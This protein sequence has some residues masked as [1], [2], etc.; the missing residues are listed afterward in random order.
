[1]SS[2]ENQ[3]NT[4]SGLPPFSTSAADHEMRDYYTDRDAPR[5]TPNQTPYLT[6]YL[7]LNARLSQVWINRWTI[8]LL[9]VLVRVLFAIQSTD[10]GLASARREAL[11]ACTS[12]EK[13]GSAMASMPHYMSQGVNKMTAS[14]ITKAVNGLESMV[15][16][17]VTGVEE[18]IV[19]Y[20]GMLTNTYLCLTTFA[21]T[22]STRAVIDVLDDAQKDINAALGTIGGDLNGAAGDLQ[23]A[24]NGI[25][26]GIN[27]FTGAKIP[28]ADFTKQIDA[29]KNVKI[30]AGL[31]DDLKKLNSSLP[32]FAEVKNVTETALRFPFEELKKT[33]AESMGR[34]EFNDSLFPV[35][36]KESLQFC[37]GNNG[38]NDF[39]DDLVHIEN[40][41]RKIFLGTLLTAAI[42]VC[43]PMAWWEIQRYR[44]LQERAKLIGTQ[45]IDPMDAVYMASRPY[46]SKTGQK[47]A[48]KFS[49]P[50]CKILARWGIAYA[51]SVPAL[52]V[53]SLGL[54]GLFSCL[55]QYSLLRTI[56][57]QVPALTDQVANFSG[58]V[59][60]KLNNA[61][62]Q[63]AD[64]TNK[65]LFAEQQKLNQDLLGWV[66]TSTEAVNNTLTTFVDETMKI[67][68]QT[69]GGTPLYDPIK[70]VFNCLVGIKVEGIQKGLT[71]VHDNAKISFPTLDKDTFSLEAL[72]KK[73]DSTSDDELL[74]DPSGKTAD[75]I[76][77]AVLRVTTAIA[78]AIRQEAIISTS[79]LI[80]EPKPM[81]AVRPDSAAPPSYAVNPDVNPHAPYTLAPHPFPRRTD[82]V[83][84][85]KPSASAHPDAWP[86]QRSLTP[87]PQQQ[88]PSRYYNN[89][90][91][92]FM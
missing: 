90:K 91:D 11:S 62:T 92:G 25:A 65:V 40:M 72:A 71:W 37:S 41:A 36:Q 22:G 43:I 44:K 52:F 34:Y 23:K 86:I 19:F 31:S 26:N 84:S 30:P 83:V 6:P 7:G 8:L 18:I 51:T 73:T 55:M 39:F 89:E 27:T 17:S 9:L 28:K 59:V 81:R 78:K 70:E 35:P 42:L 33:I 49:T 45:A 88:V 21:V 15:T 87:Q 85:E 16:L 38:I 10:S 4:R 20:I 75:E 69:F 76:S 54:A 57:K 80:C 29:L 64:G 14:G 3:Q 32:T 67:L 82:N 61:S 2:S 63:W 12:V 58:D 74:A 13:V 68:N 46:T 50:R 56:E 60:I 5:P 79:I 24:I 66:N 53:L 47:I 48:N 1:M 77:E